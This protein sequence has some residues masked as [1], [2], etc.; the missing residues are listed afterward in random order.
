MIAVKVNTVQ[1]HFPDSLERKEMHS[2]LGKSCNIKLMIGKSYSKV[3]GKLTKEDYLQAVEKMQAH[4]QRGDIYE[5][6]FLPS[7]FQKKPH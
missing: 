1:I 7:I 5:V 6:N 3:Q 4:I 2:C